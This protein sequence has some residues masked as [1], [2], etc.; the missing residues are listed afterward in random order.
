MN[1]LFENKM[2]LAHKYS[3]MFYFV[4]VLRQWVEIKVNCEK[5]AVLSLF[6]LL[7]LKNTSFCFVQR[8]YSQLP[9]NIYN[10]IYISNTCLNIFDTHISQQKHIC[11]PTQTQHLLSE[12]YELCTRGQKT[13]KNHPNNCIATHTKCHQNTTHIVPVLHNYIINIHSFTRLCDTN[14]W[15]QISLPFIRKCFA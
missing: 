9:L 11:I 4:F 14:F 2:Q 7:L 1:Q 5:V 8:K 15:S 10:Q 12:K 6:I 13:C 3:C